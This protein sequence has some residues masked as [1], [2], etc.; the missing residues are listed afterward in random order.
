MVTLGHKIL[1]GLSSTALV[2]FEAG[3]L[4]LFLF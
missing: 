1:F 4:S 2:L 3:V